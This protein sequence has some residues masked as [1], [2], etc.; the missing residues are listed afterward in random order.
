[1]NAIQI[2]HTAAVLAEMLTFK[3]PA[4]AVLSAYFREHKKLGRQDRHEIAETAF[5][6]L[7]HHQKISAALRRPAAQARKAALA[8]LVLGRSMNISQ[9]QDILDEEDKEF[10]SRLKARKAE[11]ADGITT[12]AELPQWLV[13]QLQ[14]HYTDEEVLAFG[15]SVNSAAPLDIRV[16][17]L[18]AKRD[19]V[20]AQLQ[21]EDIAAEAALFSPWGI[22]LKD[23]IVLNK[24]ELFLDGALE[25]QD[26]GSQLLALLL[27]AKRGEIVVDFC[28]GAGGKTLAIGAQMANK[29]RIYAFDVAE[30]RLANLKP[31]MTRAGLTNIHPERI[32]SE[33][34]TRIGRLHGKA[35][36]VLVDAPCSGLGTLRRNPDLKYRQSPETVTKLLAQQHS[37]LSAAADLVKPQGRLVYATCSVLP[38]E[39]EMQ[40]ERFLVEHPEFELLDCGALLAGLKIDL[41]TGKYLRLSSAEHQTD[42]FFAA[43]FQKKQ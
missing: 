1:M 35:D 25:V 27:G 11:F 19:K 41:N 7:R 23:K 38:E 14:Q 8:A 2:E 34:D 21:N 17:T 5:A 32:S 42:G 40:A 3:Q 20:L 43:V 16:N 13:E 29:G 33:H 31:R 39:N 22:R 18:K 30:K 15:R 26:E 6:A 37:I 36:R 12:A 9:I 10:L 28:A 24:H 4:D